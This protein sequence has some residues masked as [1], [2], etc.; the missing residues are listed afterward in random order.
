M[1]K[2]I[3]ITSAVMPVIAV[4]CTALYLRGGQDVFLTLA[5]T[6]ATISYHFIMR[7]I[8]G[9]IVNSIMKNHADLSRPWF[10]QRGWERKL[11]RLL[12]VKKWKG[13]VPACRPDFFDLSRHTPDEVAQAMC[14][15]E[16]THEIILPLSFLPIFAAI[17]VGAL[18]AFVITSVISA[19]MELVFIVTQ[20]FN[21]P[22]I[23]KMLARRQSAQSTQKK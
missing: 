11:Y 13:R 4:L 7:L 1:R 15:A 10:R 17:W 16:I 21:R 3:I 6:F 19:A 22:R 9:G 12:R 23:I 8:V 14:Q 2:L 18:P 5:I 20:R